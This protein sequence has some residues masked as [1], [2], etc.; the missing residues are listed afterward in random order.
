[1]VPTVS[2]SATAY[3]HRG[4]IFEWQ[5]VDAVSSG[6]YPDVEGEA[7]LN[8]FVSDIEAAEPTVEFGMYYNVSDCS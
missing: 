4:Q 1:V 7:W 2:N 8:P 6:I 3:A 5:L